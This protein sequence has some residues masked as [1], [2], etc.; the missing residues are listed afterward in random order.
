MK[1]YLLVYADSYG[2]EQ[3]DE[4]TEEILEQYENG[5]IMSIA[6]T[7]QGLAYIEGDWEPIENYK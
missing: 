4:L 6:D 3:T 5:I 1:R 2:L 7:K